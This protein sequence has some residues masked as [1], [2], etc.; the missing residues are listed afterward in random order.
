MIAQVLIL[1]KIAES[2]TAKLKI[3]SKT[4]LSKKLLEIEI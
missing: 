3:I 1:I 4:R 2:L